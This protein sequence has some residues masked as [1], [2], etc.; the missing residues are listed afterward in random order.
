[1]TCEEL[2]SLINKFCIPSGEYEYQKV[3]PSIRA[4]CDLIMA[5]FTDKD[6]NSLKY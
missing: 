3:D 5:C 2:A 1:M 4:V 6:G